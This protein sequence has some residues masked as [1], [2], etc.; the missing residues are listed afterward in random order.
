MESL[1]RYTF[2][3]GDVFARDDEIAMFLVLF[4][5]ALNDLLNANRLLVPEQ[6]HRRLLRKDPTPAEDLYLLRLVA[7]HV[8]E[9]LLLLREASARPAIKSSWR[10]SSFRARSLR[11]R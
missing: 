4:T 7:G 1:R 10:A 5:A 6:V 9:T 11:A 3:M 2:R 8:W